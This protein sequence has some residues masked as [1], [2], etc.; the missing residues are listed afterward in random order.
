MC[1]VVRLLNI[2]VYSSGVE[3]SKNQNQLHVEMQD[4]DTLIV[5]SP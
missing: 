2:E 5:Q 3:E 1:L 4:R